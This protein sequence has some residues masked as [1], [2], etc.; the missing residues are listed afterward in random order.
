[1]LKERLAADGRLYNVLRWAYQPIKALNWEQRQWR[2]RSAQ[3]RLVS[4]YLARD[5]FHGLQIGCGPTPLP[6]WI[7]TDYDSDLPADFLMDISKPLPFPD[8]SFDA[9]YGEEVIEHIDFA[10]GK[11]FLAEAHRVLKPG[12]AI[13]LTTPDAEQTCRIYLGQ[14]ERS[15]N[16]FGQFWLNE[17]EFSAEMWINSTFRFYGHKHV[18]SSGQLQAELRAAGFDQ[19]RICKPHVTGSGIEQLSGH[20][21]RYG[22]APEWIFDSTM[23]IEGQRDPA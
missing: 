19:T 5:E 17:E 13:R 22:N 9:I 3:R 23:I 11:R 21:R 4:D 1:V 14:T 8:E 7:N 16:D 6:G 18:W 10:D 15:P 20:E 12:G 2:S